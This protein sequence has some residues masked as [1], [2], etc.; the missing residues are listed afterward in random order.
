MRYEKHS[1]MPL[2]KYY[3]TWFIGLPIRLKHLW[4]SIKDA[5]NIHLMDEV[6]YNS[7]KCFV[8]NGIRYNENGERLWDILEKEWN[9]DGTR[10]KYLATDDELVKVKNWTTL[11]N[12][13]LSH[14]RWYMT[15]WYQIELREKMNGI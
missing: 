12:S 8:N 5:K 14:Y 10:N 9:T 7:K 6:I 4:I 11:K 13:C 3:K 2:K 1:Y 15:Y